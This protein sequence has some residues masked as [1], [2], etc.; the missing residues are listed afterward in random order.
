M[1]SP[2]G[3]PIRKSPH[4]EDEMYYV[5]RGK[6]VSRRGYDQVSSR[7]RALR[8]RRSRAPLLRHQRRTGSPGVLRARGKS[9][10]PPSRLCPTRSCRWRPR[11]LARRSRN[12]YL[13]RH[14]HGNATFETKSPGWEE[15][16]AN[17]HQHSR[18]VARTDDDIIGWA[19]LSRVSTRQVYAGVAEVSIYVAAAA[20]RKRHRQSAPA[21]PHRAIRAERYLDLASRNLSG[22]LKQHHPAQVVRLSRSRLAG[23]NRKARWHLEERSPVRTQK[24]DCRKMSLQRDQRTRDS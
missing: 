6:G 13:R 15:W 10:D 8:G 20:P 12:I 17:H 11:A 21:S 9:L 14:S 22:E 19:A 23:K 16:N 7:Q 18:L 2:P 4:H 3:R 5:V 24:L 1:C